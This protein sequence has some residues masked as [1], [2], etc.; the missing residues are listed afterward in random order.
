VLLQPAVMRKTST[1]NS[2]TGTTWQ[3]LLKK[4]ISLLYLPGSNAV[5]SATVDPSLLGYRLCPLS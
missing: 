5:F 4:Y 1:R 3:A 2:K